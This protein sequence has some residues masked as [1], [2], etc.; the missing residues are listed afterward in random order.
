[1]ENKITISYCHR[2]KAEAFFED[3]AVVVPGE[4]CWYWYVTDPKE[5]YWLKPPEKAEKP[6]TVEE[7]AWFMEQVNDYYK[8][9]KYPILFITEEIKHSAAETAEK[10]YRRELKWRRANKLL[11]C[12]WPALPQEHPSRFVDSVLWEAFIHN[13]RFKKL[14]DEALKKICYR[15][16]RFRRVRRRIRRMW[17]GLPEERLNWFLRKTLMDMLFEEIRSGRLERREAKKIWWLNIH[18]VVEFGIVTDMS[19]C[20]NL[21]ELLIRPQ[22]EG[23]T[24][25]EALNNG[26]NLEQNENDEFE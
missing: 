20:R 3:C 5:L 8:G 6:L 17:P 4:D 12:T 19:L 15:K 11:R 22:G 21:K 23:K 7:Q 25:N 1:M 2:E 10:V 14:V 9:K 16:L 24:E 26:R 18:E 13:A